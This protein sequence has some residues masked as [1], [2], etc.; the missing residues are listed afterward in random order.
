MDV[1]E[2]ISSRENAALIAAAPELLQALKNL[3]EDSECGRSDY[4]RHYTKNC[5]YCSAWDA[6]NKAEGR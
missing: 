2:G 1:A 5:S 3:L 6:I 4:S